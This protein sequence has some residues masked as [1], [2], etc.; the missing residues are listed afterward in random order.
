MTREEIKNNLLK[1]EEQ[2][3]KVMIAAQFQS[4]YEYLVKK[5]FLTKEDLSKINKLTEEWVRKI[6]EVTVDKIMEK[7]EKE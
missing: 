4:L 7:F 3:M 2:Q 5:G 6:N 1:D